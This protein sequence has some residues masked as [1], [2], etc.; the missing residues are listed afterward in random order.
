MVTLL[1]L[2]PSTGLLKAELTDRM[3]EQT[4]CSWTEMASAQAAARLTGIL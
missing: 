1:I 4:H 3:T 2:I